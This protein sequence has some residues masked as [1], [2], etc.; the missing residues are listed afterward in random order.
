MLILS[1][2]IHLQHALVSPKSAN[3]A[4]GARQDM[5]LDYATPAIIMMLGRK[6]L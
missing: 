5:R 4:H 1:Q 6:A 3:C 2:P